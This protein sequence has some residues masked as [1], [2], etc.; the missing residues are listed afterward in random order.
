M[1]LHR[2]GN[3]SLQNHSPWCQD[4]FEPYKMAAL[5]S[6]A[7]LGSILFFL[8]VSLCCFFFAYIDWNLDFFD[9]YWISFGCLLDV[10]GI[11][12]RISCIEV[13]S[14]ALE[15]GQWQKMVHSLFSACVI[16][17]F[18]FCIYWLKFGFL[19]YLLDFFWVSV[20][21]KFWT[22]SQGHPT[23]TQKKS[24]RY[25]RNPNFN[26]YMQKR[27]N[28]MTHA[29][30]REWTIFCHWPSSRALL[31][32]SMQENSE[33]YPKDIQQTPKRNPI[34]IKEIQI[35]INIC[36]KETTQWHMQK[37]ENGPFSVTDLVQGHY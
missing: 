14:S 4:K 34:D 33:P 37:K 3:C 20:C 21:K 7:G 28:T 13:T 26:Q 9:I 35:S 19:W 16:V 22:I 36:K 1:P 8:H 10:L 30:K 6:K 23:D 18:L 24:N 2:T 25:Q 11:W 12:F 15:L 27:N 17:L 29:E 5:G 32:T 31:V